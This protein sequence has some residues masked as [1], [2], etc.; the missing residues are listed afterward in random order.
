MT[1]IIKRRSFGMRGVSAIALVLA[2]CSSVGPAG[3]TIGSSA[4][5]LVGTDYTPTTVSNVTGQ[6][7]GSL[8]AGEGLDKLIDGST[9]TKYNVNRLKLWL[10]YQMTRPTIIASYDIKSGNDAPERDPKDWTFEGSFDG[11]T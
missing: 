1:Q 2:A 8:S 10:R 9:S 6:Y 3:E 4:S 5:A 11:F 7:A